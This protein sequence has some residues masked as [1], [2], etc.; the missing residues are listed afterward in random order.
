MG[1]VNIKNKNTNKLATKILNISNQKKT[2]YEFLKL[3]Y[4][5]KKIISNRE[6]IINLRNYFFSKYE[7]SKKRMNITKFKKVSKKISFSHFEKAFK[8]KNII[9]KIYTNSFFIYPKYPS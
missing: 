8:K 4:D 3:A 1:D 6:K 7:I 2:D 9:E 5:A